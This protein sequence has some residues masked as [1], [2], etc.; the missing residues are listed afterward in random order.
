MSPV[1]DLL[2]RLLGA[3]LVLA[4]VA[5]VCFGRRQTDRARATEAGHDP[6]QCRDCALLMHPCNRTA[7]QALSAFPRQTRGG[8]Q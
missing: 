3:V 7:R 6:R 4:L 5:S 2:F 1:V 8:G